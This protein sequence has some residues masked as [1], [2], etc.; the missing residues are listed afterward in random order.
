MSEAFRY[1]FDGVGAEQA[2][3]STRGTF[4]T[5]KPGDLM[6]GINR[7]MMESFIALTNGKAIYGEPGVAGCKGPYTIIRIV[8]EKI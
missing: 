6:D 1:A 8:I 4:V 5:D 7:A 2:P 3:W